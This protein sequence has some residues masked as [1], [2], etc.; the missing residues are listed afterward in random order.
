MKILLLDEDWSTTPHL[1]Y[2]L[3]RLKTQVVLATPSSHGYKKLKRLCRHA[4]IPKVTRPDFLDHVRAL[5]KNESANIVY[6]ICEPMQQALWALPVNE[7]I[8]VFPKTTELQRQLLSNRTRMY[9]FVADL[10]VPIPQMQLLEDQQQIDHAIT[11]LG[12]PFVLR[13]T[14]GCAGTQVAIVDSADTA[15]RAYLSLKQSSPERPFAQKFIAGR[16]CLIGGLFDHGRELQLFSQ[17]TLE[18]RGPTGPSLRVRSLSDPT[19]TAL[20]QRIFTALEWDGLA[21][22]EFIRDAAGK[23]HFLEINPRPWAA[24][25]AAHHCGAPLLRMFARYLNGMAAEQPRIFSPEVECTL[26][27]AFLQ[28]RIRARQFPRL[29]DVRAYWQSL[30]AA[31]WNRPALMRHYLEMIRWTFSEAN[32]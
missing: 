30:H 27:P 4:P 1:I 32:K 15:H 5:I 13:G 24:I 22:A 20:A 25:L 26:F 3:A 8:A 19:L 17:C 29:R 21:C 18:A 2:E 11:F 6:A 28:A 14:Q 12:L 7:S 9:E 16:R 31:P 10:G 23:Y